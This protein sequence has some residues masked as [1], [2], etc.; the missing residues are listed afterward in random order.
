VLE[1]D[2]LENEN[3]SFNTEHT[4]LNTDI[5]ALLLQIIEYEKLNNELQL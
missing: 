4:L 2:A 3:N 5:D 1:R